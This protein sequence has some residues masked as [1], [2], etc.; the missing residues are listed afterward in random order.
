MSPVTF[1]SSDAIV[2]LKYL[3]A[4]KVEIYIRNRDLKKQDL[5][6]LRPRY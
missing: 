6:A 3:E 2:R 5:F 1:A 4:K